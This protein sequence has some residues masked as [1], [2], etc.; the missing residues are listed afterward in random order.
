VIG[1]MVVVD[2]GVRLFDTHTEPG[3]D[4]DRHREGSRP[5]APASRCSL[6]LSG[7]REDGFPVDPRGNEET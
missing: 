4:V 5:V 6:G 2:R 7:Q 3:L 1:A